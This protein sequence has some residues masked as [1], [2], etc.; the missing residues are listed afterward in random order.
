MRLL[1]TNARRGAAKFSALNLTSERLAGNTNP[2][3][4]NV[5]VKGARFVDFPSQ[6][7]AFLSVGGRFERHYFRYD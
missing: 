7:G 4:E 6:A 5:N 2:D 3:Y 1:S